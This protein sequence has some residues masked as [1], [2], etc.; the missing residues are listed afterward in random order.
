MFYQPKRLMKPG[1]C[2]LAEPRHF[3]AGTAAAVGLCVLAFAGVSNL[4]A[5]FLMERDSMDNTFVI[6]SVDPTVVETFKPAEKVKENVRIQN[7]G[8]TSVYVRAAILMSW[9]DLQ[10]HVLPTD[11]PVLGADYTLTEPE[12]GW[13]LG[14][15]GYYYYTTP[16]S[17]G[18]ET[19]PLITKL[20][21]KHTDAAKRL[22]VDIV[23]QTVQASPAEA[24]TDAFPGAAIGPDGT[25]TP[26]ALEVTP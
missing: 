20:T 12:N 3:R 19:S 21:D 14:G 15:D 13:V 11:P 7:G 9:Q 23:A 2:L 18:G 5:A 10:G 16:V 6:G 24:V 1:K 22:V 4:S 8:N 26:P 25:L 17:P